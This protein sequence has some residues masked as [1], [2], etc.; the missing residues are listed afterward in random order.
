MQK[1][2]SE[3]KKLLLIFT[4]NPEKGKVKTRLAKTIG[5][6][7]ALEFYIYLLQHTQEV[8]KGLNVTKQVFYSEKI[9]ENDLWNEEIF[10]K[11]LQKGS[12]LGER[13]ENAFNYGFAEDFE[14]IIIIGS[15]LLELTA[16]DLQQ[17]FSDLE[18]HDAVIGPAKDGGYYL[19][20]MKK[21]N[22]DVFSNKKWGTDT[23]LQET[24]KDFKT[25]KVAMLRELNDIDVYEDIEDKTILNKFL[26]IK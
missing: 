18:K 23:V 5:D 8:T 24:L 22:P 13:M 4:R 10:Q 11:K 3:N 2:T 14:Q 21:L 7:A 19:L 9:P 25:E 6:D 20:G 26:K 1:P 17:A 12:D 16:T 15:D